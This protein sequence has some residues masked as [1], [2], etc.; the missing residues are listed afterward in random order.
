MTKKLERLEHLCSHYDTYF[1]YSDDYRVWAC[2]E[3][4]HAEIKRL[5]EELKGG[6][7]KEVREIIGKYYTRMKRSENP[8]SVDDWVE[9]RVK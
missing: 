4:N 3:D 1:D 5:V 8:P 2:G 9:G 6:H 7:E